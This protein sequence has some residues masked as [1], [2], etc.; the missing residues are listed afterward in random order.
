MHQRDHGHAGVLVARLVVQAL[1]DPEYELGDGGVRVGVAVQAGAHMAGRRPRDAGHDQAR[2]GDERGAR[3]DV[4]V[5]RVVEDGHRVVLALVAGA[6][7]AAG[8]AAARDGHDPSF[9]ERRAEVPLD[10]PVVRGRNLG[11]VEDVS[12]A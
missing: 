8:P 5:R 11:A 3:A 1:R 4:E 10:D 12:T 9:G 7:V 2:Q 6:V